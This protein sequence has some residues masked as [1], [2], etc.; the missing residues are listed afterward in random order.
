[1]SHVC[2]IK[3]VILSETVRLPSGLELSEVSLP[4]VPFLPLLR[5]AAAAP[6]DVSGVRWLPLDGA[7][8]ETPVE[9]CGYVNLARPVRGAPAAGEVLTQTGIRGR[10]DV[11]FDPAALAFLAEAHGA[12]QFFE[13]PE[14]RYVE[15]AAPAGGTVEMAEAIEAAAARADIDPGR[16]ALTLTRERVY[17]PV[18]GGP[19][20]ESAPPPVRSAAAARNATRIADMPPGKAPP[21]APEAPTVVLAAGAALPDGDQPGLLPGEGGVA[22]ATGRSDDPVAA[23]F[24]TLFPAAG[25]P[26]AAAPATEEPAR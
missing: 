11:V 5:F 25:G 24:A 6:G 14:G 1:M 7:A 13:L 2:E 9:F 19:P 10:R 3:P 22:A 16:W 12:G 8:L 23:L 15:V 18:L 20:A 21:A 26:A 4:E 17:V